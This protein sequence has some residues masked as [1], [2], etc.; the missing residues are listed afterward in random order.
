MNPRLSLQ[1]RMSLDG[2]NGVGDESIDLHAGS[3]SVRGSRHGRQSSIYRSQTTNLFNTFEGPDGDVA[4][5]TVSPHTS[6]HHHPHRRQPSIDLHELREADEWEQSNDYLDDD[7]DNDDERTALRKGKGGKGKNSQ[8][9]A[10]IPSPGHDNA[11]PSRS[12]D[13]NGQRAD[14]RSPSYNSSSTDV[15]IP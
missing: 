15:R 11:N 8:L 12:G 5:D 4:L 9:Q 14:G 7:H 10:K 1:G 13:L 6:R 2:W 3:G